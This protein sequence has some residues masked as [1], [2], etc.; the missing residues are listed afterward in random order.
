MDSVVFP[1]LYTLKEGSE[2]V[3]TVD[4]IKETFDRRRPFRV[5]RFWGK[6]ASYGSGPVPFQLSAYG[7][8]SAADNVWVSPILLAV[9]NG[10]RFRFNIPVTKVGWYPSDTATST[11]LL[12]VVA[13]CLH[14]SPASGITGQAYI[15]VLMQPREDD[16]S[17]PVL[18]SVLPSFHESEV[19][20]SC[21]IISESDV[22]EDEFFDSFSCSCAFW[23]NSPK[24]FKN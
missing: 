9:P 10:A 20:A 22:D 19:S 5:A 16:G 15:R 24:C 14:K 3:T 17:C 1:L 2:A 18:M 12:K 7:P 4:S 23:W 11:H 21:S 6:V 13:L 8:V